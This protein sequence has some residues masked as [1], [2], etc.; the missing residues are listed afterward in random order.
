[1]GKLLRAWSFIA[2]PVF[3]PALVS[4]WYFNYADIFDP[5]KARLK[6]YL[7]TILTA[8][9]PLLL[10][11]VLKVLKVVR[12]IHLSSPQERIVPLLIYSGILVILLKS[13]FADGQHMLL[14]Y[15]FLGV[16]IATMVATVLSVTK[17]KISLH[18]MAMGGMIG[19]AI[20]L[21]LISGVNLIVLIIILSIAS[22]LTASSRL[23]MKA[24]VGHE[25]VFGFLL[26]TVSQLLVTTYYVNAF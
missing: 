10:Y 13:V 24:H 21:T 7:I 26:G 12:S 14:Y 4:L 20:A 9:I 16:L 2:N 23:F 15:F 22:G 6:L 8:A 1:M 25:L 17:Y 3:I 19:Y 11:L 5:E 18:M